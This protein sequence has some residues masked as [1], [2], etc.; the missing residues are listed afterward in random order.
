MDTNVPNI[1]SIFMA[2]TIGHT[3]ISLKKLGYIGAYAS[4]EDEEY[5]S[6]T[7][8]FLFKI[9][10]KDAFN[11]FLKK[12]Y[13]TSK[14]I[15]KDYDYKDHVIVAYLLNPVFKEDFDLIRDG[16]YSQTSKSFQAMFPI[17]VEIIKNDELQMVSSIQ[18]KIFKKTPDLRKYWEEK[19]DTS[20]GPEQELWE[21]YDV[22]KEKLKL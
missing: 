14:L 10:N 22:E 4:V 16:K 3:I 20:I 1:T 15:I 11:T 2:P 13:N 18:Y 8:Y 9:I 7:I 6:D 19:L 21:V 17:E 5:Y 12:E